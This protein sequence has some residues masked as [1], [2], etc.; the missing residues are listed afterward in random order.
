MACSSDKDEDCVNIKKPEP[1][2]T[3]NLQPC[4][5]WKSGSWSKVSLVELIM[6]YSVPKGVMVCSSPLRVSPDILQSHFCYVLDSVQTAVGWQEGNTVMSSVST[7][8]VAV[9]SDP[10]TVKMCPADLPAR[11][12]AHKSPV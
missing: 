4:A 8:R 12:H 10:S 5:N 11:W 9:L 7:L 6:T 2:R 3:C 1:A